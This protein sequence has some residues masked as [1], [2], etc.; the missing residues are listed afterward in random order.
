MIQALTDLIR[1]LARDGDLPRD[2]VDAPLDEETTLE[3]LSLDSLGRMNLVAALDDRMGI[4]IPENLVTP[5]VT[6]GMLAE[7]LRKR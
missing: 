2:L 5:D 3:S 6:L 4:Y 1:E 7:K